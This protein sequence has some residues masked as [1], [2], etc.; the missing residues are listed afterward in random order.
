MPARVSRPTAPRTAG[1]QLARMVGVD[2]DIDRLLGLQ[3]RD[4]RRPHPPR[5]D[6]RHARVKADHRDMRDRV[7]R[8]DDRRDPP[9]RQQERVAAGDDDLPD[10]RPLRG[11]RRRRGRAPPRSSIAAPL[12][13]PARGESRTGNRPGRPGSASAAP[14]RD[15][16]AR[17]PAPATSAR[18][19]SGRRRSS[20]AVSSSAALGT[21]CAAIGSAGSA[22][23]ISAATSSVSATAIPLGHPPHLVEP[24]R[25]DEPARNQIVGTQGHRPTSSR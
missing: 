5:V 9:R 15:S 4:Q 10:L 1:G 17:S 23:S 18:R 7:Q 13:R 12:A 25:R 14:G 20:G 2:H 3:R 21:N 19:R 6:H 22:G 11:Y 8:R 16:D 24:L